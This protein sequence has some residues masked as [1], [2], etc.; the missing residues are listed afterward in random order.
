MHIIVTSAGY[1][2]VEAEILRQG[3]QGLLDGLEEGLII[4]EN[5]KDK[6]YSTLF[7]NESVKQQIKII[8]K[9]QKGEAKLRIDEKKFALCPIQIF[10]KSIA[11]LP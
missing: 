2:F 5:D 10:T 4:L 9:G 3:N 1:L 6:Q 11:D 7:L 8:F